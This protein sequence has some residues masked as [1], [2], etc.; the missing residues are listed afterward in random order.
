MDGY[1]GGQIDAALL[2]SS[3]RRARSGGHAVVTGMVQPRVEA[4]LQAFCGALAPM[5]FWSDGNPE[6]DVTAAL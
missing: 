2:H 1:V 4:V 3:R 5:I 6:A